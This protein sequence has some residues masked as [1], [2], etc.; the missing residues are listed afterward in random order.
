MT[1]I[2]LIAIDL[3]GTLLTDDKK[4][5]G[6][7][8][9]ALKQAME[10]GIRVVI[11]T[12]RNI[13]STKPF[14]QELGYDGDGQYLISQNGAAIHQIPDYTLILDHDIP[15]EDRRGFIDFFSQFENLP[16]IGGNCD[17][18]LYSGLDR[19]PE[20]VEQEASLLQTPLQPV[21]LG[22]LARCHPIYNLFV[23]A[24]PE[25][26]DALD[27]QIPASVRAEV[28]VVRSLPQ[29]IEC[30]AKGVSKASTLQDL[31]LELGL[32]RE[33]V[34]AIGDEQNDLEMIEEAGTGVAVANAN[35]LVKERADWVTEADNNHGAV[36]E[37]VHRLLNQEAG[38]DHLV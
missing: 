2:R 5:T 19:L 20:R 30:N 34:M 1:Q 33:E 12:G 36:A 17:I 27:H 38:E 4:L 13:N 23:M 21:S 25:M 6:E 9:R 11:C 37:V 16:I 28:S 32:R 7:N 22:D 18:L 3:D 14:V 35:P 10:A 8:S 24:K 31:A 29:L 15:E 26:I